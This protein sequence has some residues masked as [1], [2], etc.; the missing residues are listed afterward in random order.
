[1]HSSA[2]GGSDEIRTAQMTMLMGDMKSEYDKGNYVICGGD[3]NHDFTGTSTK[4]LN[5][6]SDVDFG[7][8]QPFP[9]NLIPRVSQSA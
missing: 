1:M 5:G 7:W 8:A 4:D 3:F 6:G 9:D 2:Y